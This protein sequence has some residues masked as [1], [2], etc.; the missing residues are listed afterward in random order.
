M[1]ERL[2]YRSDILSSSSKKTDHFS[3]PDRID[4]SSEDSC[5]GLDAVATV[6]HSVRE[7]VDDNNQSHTFPDLVSNRV[8]PRHWL[9]EGVS[10]LFLVALGQF[11]ALLSLLLMSRS[12]STEVF[13][14][15][16]SGI[17]VQN[18]VVIIGTLGLRT[19]VVRDL[20][21]NPQE[22]GSIW[23]TYWLMLG[24]VGILVASIGHI[25]SGYLF[26]RSEPEVWM[27][28]WLSCGAY[29]SILSLVPLLDALG[30][31]SIALG[32]VAVTEVAFFTA[33]F[34]GWIPLDIATLGG[35]FAIKW[36][37]ASL[38][39]VCTLYFSTRPVRFTFCVEQSKRWMRS[40]FPLLVTGV[41]MNLP[42]MGAVIMT[43]RF[44]SNKETAVM[45]LAAQLAA[46][47]LLIG[48]VAIRYIQ[49]IWR[50]R[51]TLQDANTNKTVRFMAV[52]G[53]ICWFLAISGV[54]IIVQYW[55]PAEYTV[56]LLTIFVM[57]MTAAFG[58]VARVLWVALLA[59]DQERIVLMSYSVG[60]G[61]FISFSIGLASSFRTEGIA[62][63][64][65]LG[66]GATVTLMWIKVRPLLRQNP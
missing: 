49:P 15:L 21:R 4:R 20:A 55:L 48:G 3:H 52:A 6:M 50:D 59:A 17:A 38:L 53:V 60:C 11:S 63:A 58:V 57:M 32:I 30:R 16:S 61:I 25:I 41:I 2:S 34:S 5:V 31:Q 8:S 51:T 56:G 66:M 29:F 62:F 7:P 26:S 42:I 43:R 36:F 1:S 54:Y 28:L 40:A 65:A 39:Q 9:R 64:A 27:S 14:Q 23:G 33:L 18:Y 45:G 35:A 37:S 22:L 47:V 12:V 24:P 13:G 44:L 10:V 19:L 46:A